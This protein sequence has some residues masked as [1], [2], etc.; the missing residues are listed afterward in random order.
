[1]HHAS[2][3]WVNHTSCLLAVSSC[4][5]VCSTTTRRKPGEATSA[6]PDAGEEF[7]LEKTFLCWKNDVEDPRVGVELQCMQ[8]WLWKPLTTMWTHYC[9]RQEYDDRIMAAFLCAEYLE[10]IRGTCS[11][12]DPLGC[13]HCDYLAKWSHYVLRDGAVGMKIHEQTSAKGT[14]NIAEAYQE[15]ILPMLKASDVPLPVREILSVPVE[16]LQR[17]LLAI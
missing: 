8:C 5:K 14:Y 16:T 7:S 15:I 2:P 6:P 12:P 1:M 13:Q 10:I 9:E 17:S 11:S 3:E 4:S